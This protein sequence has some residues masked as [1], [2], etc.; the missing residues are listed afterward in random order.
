MNAW[1][2][3]TGMHVMALSIALIFSTVVCTGATRADS[4]WNNS[5]GQPASFYSTTK[6]EY[7]IGDIITILIVE[8][9]RATNTT[10]LN[11]DKETDLEMGF[12]SFDDIFGLTHVFGQPLS[13]NPQFNLN[14]ESE[15]DGGG[16]SRRSSAITGT[17]SG[18]I[19]EILPN[20]NLRIEA[21]Q[22]LAINGEKNSVIL[23]G[24]IRPQDISSQNT[25]L[26]TKVA[27]AEIKYAGKGPL[28]NVQKRGVIT[29]F[30]E[31]IWPF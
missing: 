23:V 19:T 10:D 29:E 22:A 9:F 21:S 2:R 6:G 1:S 18:Q 16:S 31:F 26:S 11:T 4:I 28:S 13:A 17:I 20:G 12:D 5:N 8:S 30:L 27:S 7:K 25:V 24:T 3:K 14:A 15:F